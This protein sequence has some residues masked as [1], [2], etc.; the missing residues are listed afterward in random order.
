RCLN[1][2]R[3]FVRQQVMRKP[4]ITWDFF[5]DFLE[6]IFHLPLIAKIYSQQFRERI[7]DHPVGSR[8]ANWWYY[9]AH[10]LDLRAVIDLRA[11]RFPETCHGQDNIGELGCW[12]EKHFLDNK[13]I[14]F[15]QL[16]F[17]NRRRITP[18]L[19]HQVFS[20]EI[21]SLDPTAG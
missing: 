15:G 6:Y 19:S 1:L 3:A 11:L 8:L 13:E 10:K 20:G 9:A 14:E 5:R 2:S 16:R 7:D 12:S 18:G 17:D 21:K 4:R